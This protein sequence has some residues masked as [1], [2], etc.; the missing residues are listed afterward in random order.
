M[1]NSGSFREEHQINQRIHRQVNEEM[2]QRSGRTNCLWMTYEG[3]RNMTPN[4]RLAFNHA[5]DIVREA[6]EQT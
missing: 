3:W 5:F 6:H 2:N 4:Q 1:T